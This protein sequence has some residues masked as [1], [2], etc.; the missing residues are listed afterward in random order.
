MRRLLIAVVSAAALMAL[1][2]TA[3]YVTTAPPLLSLLLEPLSLLLLP[4]LLVS[5]VSAGPHDFSPGLV[6]YVAFGFYVA[7]IY[8]LLWLWWEPRRLQA[9]SR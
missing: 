9:D 4:G 1:A 6:I 3:M 7:L 2:V 8:L 5:I